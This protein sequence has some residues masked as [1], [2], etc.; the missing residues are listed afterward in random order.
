MISDE[1]QMTFGTSFQLSCVD[2]ASIEA[3]GMILT[4]DPGRQTLTLHSGSVKVAR[5]YFQPSP[6]IQVIKD[7]YQ[8]EQLLSA[9]RK[10]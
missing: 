2:A 6:N 10:S 3:L 5:V 1:S 8:V 7:C 4:L 9:S